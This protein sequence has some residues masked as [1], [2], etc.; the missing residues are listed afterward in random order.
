MDVFSWDIARAQGTFTLSQQQD[1]LYKNI[2]VYMYNNITI[3]ITIIILFFLFIFFFLL[4]V[5]KVCL[6]TL[7]DYLSER[8]EFIML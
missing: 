5:V 6:I 2:H 1:K 4:I 8:D 3:I 7:L